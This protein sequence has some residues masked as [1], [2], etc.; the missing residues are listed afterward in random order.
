MGGVPSGPLSKSLTVRQR[1]IR[2]YSRPVLIVGFVFPATCLLAGCGAGGDLISTV[3]LPS[4]QTTGYAEGVDL[5]V[6]PDS[7]RQSGEPDLTPSQRE[8][9]GALAAAGVHP[10]SDLRALSI[11]AYVCQAQAAG[12]SDQTVWD[13]VAPMVRSEVINAST[14][15]PRPSTV[16]NV[17]EVVGTVIQIATQRLC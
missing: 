15:S 6:S 4:Q 9:L 3:A 16:T 10:A 2:T 17:D 12:Q 13:S 5:P 8:Y 14:E 1:I 11:G 7:G